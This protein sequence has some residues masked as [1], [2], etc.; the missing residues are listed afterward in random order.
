[1]TEKPKILAIDDAPMVLRAICEVL[2]D[3]CEVFIAK[4]GEAGIEMAKKKHPDLILLDIVM[5]GMSGFD[6]I[7][8]LKKD[9]ET[10]GIPVVM[11]TGSE[12]PSDEKKG[13]MLGAVD[14]IKKPFDLDLLKSKV[15][16][17]LSKR[18]GGTQ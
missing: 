12:I 9:P 15:E 2:K 14:F 17:I 4:S 13:Y 7:E 3:T 8:A 18:T 1:M 16:L 10:R 6:T 5:P 11:V